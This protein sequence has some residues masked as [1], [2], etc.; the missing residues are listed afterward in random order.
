[1]KSALIKEFRHHGPYTFLGAAVSVILMMTIR[2]WWP[3]V[4]DTERTLQL[5]EFSH[6]L[7]VV[8]SAMVTATV[9][10]KYRQNKSWK[11]IAAVILVGYFGAIGI[12]TLS[13]CIVPFWAETILRMDAHLHLGIVEIPFIINFAALLGIS[14]AFFSPKTYIPHAGHILL[15]TMASLFHIMTAHAGKFSFGQGALIIVFLFIAVWVP[16]CFSDIAFPVL[17]TGKC[18]HCHED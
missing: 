18:D 14:M 13:D 7:H 6:P 3:A 1:M 2:H 10:K 11:G 9:F 17:F 16:C 15:S 5:F 4:L 12:A 8:L